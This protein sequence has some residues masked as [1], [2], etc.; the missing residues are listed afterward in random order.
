MSVLL[1]SER[2][3]KFKMLKINPSSRLITS[4]LLFAVLCTST[5]GKTIYVDDDATGTND[6]TSWENAYM[7]LQDALADANSIEKPVEIRVAQGIYKPDQG[8]NQILGNREATF[9][10]I[11]GVTIKGGYA[12]LIE[13]DPN[14][15]DITSYRTILSGDLNSDDIQIADPCDLYDEP[16]RIENSYNIITAFKADETT[17]LD[18]FVI[19]GGNA[20]GPVLHNEYPDEFR[21]QFGGG[22]YNKEGD[23]TLFNCTFT[24]NSASDGGGLC[25]SGGNPILTNCVFNANFAKSNGG[26]MYNSWNPWY[27]EQCTPTLIKCTFTANVA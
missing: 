7:L 16:T 27:Q 26:G 1:L 8:A 20:K 19:T 22:M 21:L 25:N 15:K 24:E 2:K 10:L 12:G 13:A 17:V 3:G 9:Q 11:N 14:V 18:G 4:I 6:G 23:P 5:F